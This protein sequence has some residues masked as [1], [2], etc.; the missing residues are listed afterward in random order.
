MEALQ[1]ISQGM[2]VPYP[3]LYG[4]MSFLHHVFPDARGKF[5]IRFCES[6]PC[7]IWG[8]DDL[9]EVVQGRTGNQACGRDHHGRSL[10]PGA[11]CLPGGLRRSR[12]PCRYNEVVFGHLTPERIKNIIRRNYRA[13]KTV[14]YK[15]LPRT[16]NALSD[17]PASGDELVLLANATRS[18]P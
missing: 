2:D 13:G 5:I 3:Y 12:R 17:Y 1:L 16:T 11:H 15:T 9:V 6:P 18:T 4:V 14:D 7:H 10:H 8:A